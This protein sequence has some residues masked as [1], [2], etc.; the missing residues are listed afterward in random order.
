DDYESFYDSL[1]AA[2]TA[3]SNAEAFA[4]SAVATETSRAEAAEALLA[5]KAS[6]TF[7]G[8]VSGIN[9]AD[10]GSLPTLAATKA[11][12]TSN[13]FTAYNATTGLFSA[14]QPSPADLSVG[15]LTTGITAATNAI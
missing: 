5:P 14:A 3:Q 13:F 6:P 7:T 8:T 9:Y 12:I 15:A 1:G 2:D 4:T 10:L 11:A